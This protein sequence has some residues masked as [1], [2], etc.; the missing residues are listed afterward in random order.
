MSET[1]VTLDAMPRTVEEF[2][3]M[4]DRLATTPFGGAAMFAVALNVYS[5][6]PKAGIPLLTLALD[7]S[8]LSDGNEGVSGK[9]PTHL[10]D[11]RDRNGQKPWV[12]KSMIQ[13]TSPEGGYALPAFPLTLKFKEQPGDVK[14]TDAKVFVY[15]TGADSP[16]PMRLKKNDKGLWKA[17]EWS[18]FQGNCRPPV[19]KQSDDL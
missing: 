6:D 19:V 10:R 11:F 3:A 17:A 8:M 18:S 5:E 16:K 7:A 15:T 14:E 1:T 2:K 9:Q 13:G 4:R 12:A